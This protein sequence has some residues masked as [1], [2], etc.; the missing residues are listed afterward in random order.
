VNDKCCRDLGYTRDELLSL[1]VFDIDPTLNESFLAR[2]DK[3]FDQSGFMTFESLHRRKD[4][5]TYPVEINLKR[6]ELD[7]VYAVNV[8]RDI[9]Q[10]KRD[11]GG[12]ASKRRG[13][14]G[15][16]AFGSIRKLAVGCTD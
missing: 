5:S 15:S 2:I 9:T 16:P 10:R 14:Y 8:V 1:R 7:R 6:V 3:E 4:G 12:A 13:T 11:R